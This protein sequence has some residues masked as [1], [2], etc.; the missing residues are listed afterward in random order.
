MRQLVELGRQKGYLL[1]DEIYE[2]LP[3]EIVSMTED[4]DQVYVRFGQLGP[5][6]DLDP[7]QKT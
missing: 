5:I 6:E 2:I 4:L 1:Y 7:E 3:E